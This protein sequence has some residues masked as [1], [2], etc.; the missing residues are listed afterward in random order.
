VPPA[1][2]TTTGR[3]VGRLVRAAHHRPGRHRAGRCGWTGSI[4]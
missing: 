1:C 3:P 4:C 2:Y